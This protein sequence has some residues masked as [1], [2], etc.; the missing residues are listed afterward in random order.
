[1]KRRIA[2][3]L[4]NGILCSHFGHCQQFALIDADTSSIS[5]AQLVTPP[6]HEPGLLPGWLAQ[7]G[8]T[9]V[10]AGGMGQRAI[11]LFNQHNINVF[12]G[13]PV[14]QPGDL[15]NKLLNN[16]LVPGANYCDH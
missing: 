7:K 6:P 15:A 11:N 9:D 2:I 1:M 13:A 3:P 14:K 5:G 12:V 4:E 8:V 16:S 10:I